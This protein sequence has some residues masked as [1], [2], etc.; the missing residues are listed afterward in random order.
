M[1]RLICWLRGHDWFP[2]I[3]AREWL[4]VKS[5]C[6]RCSATTLTMPY[7]ECLGGHPV[8]EHYDLAGKEHPLSEDICK[9]VWAS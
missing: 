3:Q 9:T 4:P 2:P 6:L 1:T 7:G 5:G 8:V